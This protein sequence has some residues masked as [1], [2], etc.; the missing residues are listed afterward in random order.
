MGIEVS[1]FLGFIIL[2]LV[3]WAIIKIVG[4][5]ASTIRKVIWIAIVL[6][7]PV[8]GVVLWYFLGPKG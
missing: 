1:G 8:L 2:L 3:I 6:L 5:T 4:S 7:L